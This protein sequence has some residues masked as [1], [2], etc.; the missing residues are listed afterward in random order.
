[1]DFLFNKLV[2]QI[3]IDCVSRA[4]RK[5]HRNRVLDHLVLILLDDSQNRSEA[6][7]ATGYN[8]LWYSGFFPEV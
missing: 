5:G 3:R 8:C 6:F 2:L 1:M 4:N 7:S